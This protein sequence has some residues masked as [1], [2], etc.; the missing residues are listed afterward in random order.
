MEMRFGLCLPRD[1]ATVPI[2]RHVVRD[3][4]RGLSVASGCISDIE[5]A[6][7]EACS[8]VLK[9]AVNTRGDY[10]VEVVIDERHC[11][12]RVID[13]GPTFDNQ[14]LGFEQAKASAEGGRGIFLMRALVDDLKF[15][16]RSEDG[17]VV[18]LEKNLEFLTGSVVHRL[19]SASR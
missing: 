9:H 7:T 19:A 5:V 16:N 14:P 4:L 6:V 17:T 18:H 2:V 11:T 1:E 8:N 13:A 12:I 15:V 10:E 3:A